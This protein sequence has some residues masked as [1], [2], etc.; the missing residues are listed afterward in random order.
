LNFNAIENY[1]EFFLY[2]CDD[3]LW[4]LKTSNYKKIEKTRTMKA[5]ILDLNNNTP[6]RGI[7]YLKK[8]LETAGLPYEVFDVRHRG[9]MP[10]LSFDLYFSSGGP[11]SPFDFEGGWDKKYFEWIENIWQ[12]NLKS[13]EKKYIFFICHSFQL[14]C[15][16]FDVGEI[17]KRRKRSFGTFPCYKT[18]TG[19]SEIAFEG[20]PNPFY[21]ADFRDW[22]VVGFDENELASRGFQALALEKPR[23]HVDLPR[24]LMAIRFSDEMIATQFHPEADAE[25]M[26]AHF[27]DASRKEQVME[28]FGEARYHQMI[29][30]LTDDNKIELTFKTILPNFIKAATSQRS[31]A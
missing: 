16:H 8:M 23:P 27:Q 29:E 11:G 26:A 14:A 21:I 4:I 24:A 20:L 17:K 6:N 3:I 18:M 9:E 12:H 1:F 5:A 19:R 2:L 28:D 30:D 7:S 10:D 13:D 15:Q 22:Q 25:G 31:L